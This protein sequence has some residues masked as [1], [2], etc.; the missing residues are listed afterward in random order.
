MKKIKTAGNKPCLTV[1]SSFQEENNAEHVR[2]AMM[3]PTQ[4]LDEFALLQ[5]RLWGKKWTHGRMVRTV[6]VEKL[7]WYP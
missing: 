2:L 1:F 6:K 7:D 4:R 5:E 3:T